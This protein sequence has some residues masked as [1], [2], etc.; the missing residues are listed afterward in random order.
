MEE[1]YLL[2]GH[3]RLKT[4][5]RIILPLGAPGIAAMFT[6]SAETA[7]LSAYGAYSLFNFIGSW[8]YSAS[9]ESSSYQA[10]FGKWMLG[11]RVCDLEGQRISFGRASARSTST[12]VR[13]C[14]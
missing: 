2:D 4:F 5:F 6:E 10:T 14:C 13:F 9:M 11:I 3:S 7:F 1:S 12:A 8:L